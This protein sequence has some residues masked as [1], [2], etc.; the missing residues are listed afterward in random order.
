MKI[1]LKL[2]I[3]MILIVFLSFGFSSIVTARGVDTGRWG[4]IYD[5]PQEGND[6]IFTIG[7]T[8]IG[9]IQIVSAGIAVIMLIMLGIRYAISSP[10]QRADIKKGMVP[11]IIG[12]VILFGATSLI[13]LVVGFTEQL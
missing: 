2:I 4:H 11:F 7:N 9:V 10:N 1:K 13:K 3:V 8:I 6:G 12:A 5:N